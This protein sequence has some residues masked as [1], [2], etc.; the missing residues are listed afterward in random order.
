MSRNLRVSSIY[1]LAQEY[2]ADLKLQS[3]S[4]SARSTS[5]TASTSS[6]DTIRS[7]YGVELAHTFDASILDCLDDD[8]LLEP[9][10]AFANVCLTSVNGGYAYSYSHSRGGS[11]S[12]GS[13][14]SSSPPPSPS[15]ARRSLWV[16]NGLAPS[17]SDDD[18]EDGD[19]DDFYSSEIETDVGAY[20]SLDK[21]A[22]WE[23]ES[24]R[25]VSLINF[26]SQSRFPACEDLFLI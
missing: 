10:S 15:D 14:P 2:C 7:M 17:Y 20:S 12:S 25:S 3:I 5:S 18:S 4:P 8:V 21:I 11:C 9:S 16:H 1:Q 24:Y 19:D 6:A 22:P 26:V 13:S 23:N